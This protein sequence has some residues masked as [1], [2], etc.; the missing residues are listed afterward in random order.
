MKRF[1]AALS[2]VALAATSCSGGHSISSLV[3]RDGVSGGAGSP[4]SGARSTANVQI[5]HEAVA[6]AGWTKTSTHV[7]LMGNFPVSHTVSDTGPMDTSKTLK[8]EVGLALHNFTG[9][10]Q[11][12]A[13]GQVLSPAQVLASYGPTSSDVSAVTSYLKTQGFTN[14]ATAR[15]NLLVQATGTVAQIQQAFNTSLETYNFD[16]KPVYANTQSAAYV[17]TALSGIVVGVLGLNNIQNFG[18]SPHKNRAAATP[19]QPLANTGGAASPGTPESA[20]SLS[21]I[22]IV[23]LPNPAPEPSPVP[24]AAGCLR[25]YAPA[26][27]WRAYDGAAGEAPNGAATNIAIMAEGDVSGS[28]A[29]FRVNEQG[30]GLAQ[31]P[32]TVEQVGPP[33]T[34][35]AGADEWTLDMSA[36]S[37]IA[38]LVKGVYVYDTTSLTDSDI[39]LEYNHWV[40]DDIAQVGNSSF[41][42][43][44]YAPYLDG[45]MLMI[46]EMLAEAAVQGQTMFASSGDTGSFCSVGT[47]NGVPAGVPLVEYPAA[48][49]YVV[50]V[51]GT[52][53]D[54][55]LNGSYQGELS[56]DAG[57]GGISQF[58]Y[59]PIWQNGVQPTNNANVPATFRGVPDIAMDADLQTGMILY[60]ASTGWTVIGGTSLASP[61]AAG[62][63]SMVLHQR[64]DLGY[65]AVSLYHTYSNTT[66]G[67]TSTMFP[68]TG[69]HGPYHDVLFGGN[70]F[71]TAK[72]SFDY[73][74]GMGTLDI[75]L[76]TK[77]AVE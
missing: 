19:P 65:A 69:V 2:L 20:C 44:E 41:G 63:W 38:R 21:S 75:G 34:D 61:L 43:C 23:G 36:S 31:V 71:Y 10:Q 22:N 8:I 12:I 76:L 46:D 42:G 62:A 30:D 3:P 5:G 49:P 28:I 32:V 55:A 48:S 77:Q 57:G 7:W 15:N 59:S 37:G 24:G 27:F 18:I 4:Q 58:E 52:T 68:E 9:L 33:S 1:A 73:N 26:D 51:G 56:W 53:L 67:T 16:G 11:A 40:A 60:T 47:P 74:T 25:N 70:G 66:A 50:A 39:A 17:P 45:S 72:P 6:P 13:A 64:T 54:T 14:V 35:T 29:D